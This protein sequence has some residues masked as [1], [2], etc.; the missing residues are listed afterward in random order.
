MAIEVPSDRLFSEEHEWI[1]IDG[2]QATVGITDHAQCS[3]GD[4]VY[5]ELPAVGSVIVQ[6]RP[7]GVVESVK[8]VSDLYAPVSGVVKAV[9]TT[10]INNPERINLD[11]YG[12]GWMLMLELS[13]ETEQNKLL[14]KLH[15]EELIN[16]EAK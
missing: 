8:A 5:V 13:N 4:V 3:L 16:A 6:G 9:N 1:K 2:A 11:P 10:L 12:E 14:D 7:I 15:Y